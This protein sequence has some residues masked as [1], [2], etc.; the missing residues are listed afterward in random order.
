MKRIFSQNRPDASTRAEWP[1]TGGFRVFLHK[2]QRG[3]AVVELSLM[4]TFLA[5]ILLGLVIVHELGVKNIFAMEALRHEMRISMLNNARNPFAPNTVEK[6]VFVDIPGKM[7]QVFGAPDIRTHHQIEFY[8]GSYQ[9]PGD[10]K[11]NRRFLY[12]KI[13]LQN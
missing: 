8:E 7:K 2:N 12:R 11:Y 5:V 10:S 9:G 3:Q 13:D 1:P 6:D 4:M